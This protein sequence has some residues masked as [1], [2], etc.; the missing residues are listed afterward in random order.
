VNAQYD[1]YLQDG[2]T[3]TYWSQVLPGRPN[4]GV[5]ITCF[6]AFDMNNHQTQN[7]LNEWYMQTLQHTTQDQI[8]FPYALFKTHIAPFSLPREGI[9]G[10]TP[11]KETAFYVKMAHGL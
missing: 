3:E 5:W 6:I 8:S 1:A 9:W 11:H 2:Y 7:F 4:A 10:D